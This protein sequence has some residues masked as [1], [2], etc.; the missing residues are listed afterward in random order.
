MKCTRN[1]I[2]SKP[3]SLSL[4]FPSNL[5]HTLLNRCLDNGR[6]YKLLNRRYRFSLVTLNIRER[7]A[8]IPRQNTKM[9]GLTIEDDHATQDDIEQKIA[10]SERDARGRFK[11]ESHQRRAI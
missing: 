5:E 10:M 11:E 2:S 1:K 4:V 7:G 8:S 6:W 9:I 3:K